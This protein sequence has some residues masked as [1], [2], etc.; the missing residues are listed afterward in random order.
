M[1]SRE[2]ILACRSVSLKSLGMEGKEEMWSEVGIEGK[3]QWEKKETF[4]KA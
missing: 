3:K 2:R 4:V 1:E